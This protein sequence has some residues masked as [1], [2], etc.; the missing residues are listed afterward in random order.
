MTWAIQAHATVPLRTPPPDNTISEHFIRLWTQEMSVQMGHALRTWFLVPIN[1][2]LDFNI[3]FWQLPP[4]Q[5]YANID[6]CYTSPF[7]QSRSFFL[8]NIIYF[9]LILIFPCGRTVARGCH[10]Y[11]HTGRRRV[12]IHTYCMHVSKGQAGGRGALILQSSI[13]I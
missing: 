13:M 11:V 9:N 7:R 1:N 5:L 8:H 12:K 4:C 2:S 6:L 10:M 3:F